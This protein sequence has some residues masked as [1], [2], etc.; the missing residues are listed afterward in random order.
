LTLIT[1]VALCVIAVI[2]LKYRQDT[3]NEQAVIDSI[4]KG[5]LKDATNLA[6]K[7]YNTPKRDKAYEKLS[8]AYFRKIDFV[9]AELMAERISS[10]ELQNKVLLQIRF[11]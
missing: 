10:S 8:L 6:L 2:G 11:R 4:K 7:I 1:T 3:Q 9:N 5:N